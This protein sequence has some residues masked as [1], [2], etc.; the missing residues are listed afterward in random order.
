MNLFPVSIA[1]QTE[2]ESS[3]YIHTEIDVC[4]RF[5]KCSKN[6][7]SKGR[8]PCLQVCNIW[9]QK[10]GPVN[11]ELS[12]QAVKEKK[13]LAELVTSQQDIS[14]KLRFALYRIWD[15]R[16][17]EETQASGSQRWQCRALQLAVRCRRTYIA[18][19]I[20]AF[21]NQLCNN[22]LFIILDI[23]ALFLVVTAFVGRWIESV[24]V[25]LPVS[26]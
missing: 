25:T 18:S 1:A 10:S 13:P 24:I 21:Q 12:N 20:M 9:L 4:G 26:L 2:Q 16:R 5:R 15:W 14:T 19:Y 23:G 8:G 7:H 3:R 22:I 6:I 17:V 11:A